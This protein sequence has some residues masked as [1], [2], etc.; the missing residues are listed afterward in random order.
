MTS[1]FMYLMDPERHAPYG[2]LGTLDWFYRYKCDVEGEVW[3]PVPEDAYTAVGPVRV[4]DRLWF[5]FTHAV[6]PLVVGAV[7]IIAVRGPGLEATMELW[8]R[9]EAVRAAVMFHTGGV[10]PLGTGPGLFRL[11]AERADEYLVF[12]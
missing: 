6:S 8:Y 4:G 7:T 9:G 1:D 5:A 11:P 3:V 10:M 2:T 12:L